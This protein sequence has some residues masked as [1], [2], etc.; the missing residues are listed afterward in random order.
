MSHRPAKFAPKLKPLPRSTTRRQIRAIHFSPT[1]Q[2]SGNVILRETIRAAFL[3]WQESLKISR[4]FYSRTTSFG[5]V[6]RPVWDFHVFVTTG[7]DK[8]NCRSTT[9]RITSSNM[10]FILQI[11]A[12]CL[13][14]TSIAERTVADKWHI[15]KP[16]DALSTIASSPLVFRIHRRQYRT[17]DIRSS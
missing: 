13:G 7:I 5:C 2:A 10:V 11:V 9:K 15:Y 16:F 6:P 8:T 3:C 1:R 17:L 14:T 12:L 4:C